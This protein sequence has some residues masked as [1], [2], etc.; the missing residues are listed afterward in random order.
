[1]AFANFRSGHGFD[2]ED[3]DYQS[4]GGLL[5][6]LRQAM[7]QEALPKGSDLGAGSNPTFRQ[8]SSRYG[9]PQGLFGRL[10]AVQAAQGLPDDGSSGALPFAPNIGSSLPLRSSS[11]RPSIS[12]PPTQLAAA[13]KS[14]LPPNKPT[15][16]YGSGPLPKADGRVGGAITRPYSRPPNATTPKQRAARQGEPCTN[17]G[18]IAPKMYANHIDPLVVEYYRNGTIDTAKM[19]SPDAVN[20]Q[21]PTCSARQGGFLSNFSKAMRRQLGLEEP[22]D[23]SN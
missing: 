21:C 4:A 8:L 7:Q 9:N 12:E 3:H 10:L 19:R 11:P 1:M 13:A 22:G 15:L 17:C 20:A 18:T 14:M 6:L 2:P 23:D 5:G 16:T